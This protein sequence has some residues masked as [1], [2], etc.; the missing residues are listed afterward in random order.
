VL[1]HRQ[2]LRE[3]CAAGYHAGVGRSAKLK[4]SVESREEGLCDI[5][6]D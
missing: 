6:D 3:N 2:I 1:G 4:A 5:V